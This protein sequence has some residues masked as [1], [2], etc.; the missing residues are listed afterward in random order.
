MTE[1]PTYEVKLDRD[2]TVTFLCP[3]GETHTH[4]GE[5]MKPGVPEHLV[6]HCAD[7]S[8]HP[9]GYMIVLPAALART[10]EG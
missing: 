8:L 4:G 10:G 9:G 7:R 6:A 1:M 3:C 2:G 5:G